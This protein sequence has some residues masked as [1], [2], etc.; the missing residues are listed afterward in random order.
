MVPRH[1][2]T[3]RTL[4][5]NG[6]NLLASQDN[7]AVRY[8]GMGNG[9]YEKVAEL[10]EQVV[11]VQERT[12]TPD[13]PDLLQSQQLLEEVHEQRPKRM[14]KPHLPLERR[15]DLLSAPGE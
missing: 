15:S 2:N 5:P 7:L 10:L 11:A 8:N 4:A 9:H 14:P 6:I 12:L 13:D 3:Q 1:T